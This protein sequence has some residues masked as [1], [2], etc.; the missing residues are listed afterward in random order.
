MGQ[1]I[2]ITPV[3]IMH[4]NLSVEITTSFDVSQPAPFSNGTTEVIPRVGV[5]VKEDKARNV[6][7]KQ[8]ATVEELVRALGSI[9]ATPRDVIAILQNLKVAG[10]LA[11]DV[12]II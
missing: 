2:Q 6:I 8:G 11:A 4:G 10:A 12:E 9:G 3:A 7:L 1:D 5:G